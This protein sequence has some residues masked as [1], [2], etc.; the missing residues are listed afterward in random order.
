MTLEWNAVTNYQ[1]DMF[2]FEQ[3]FDMN[4]TNQFFLSSSSTN[5][6]CERRSGDWFRLSYITLE[7]EWSDTAEFGRT[8]GNVAIFVWK[9]TTNLLWAQTNP[10]DSRFWTGRDLTITRSNW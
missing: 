6:Q 5:Y 3:G 1:V 8:N 9:D 2:L 7:G 10:V 4:Y